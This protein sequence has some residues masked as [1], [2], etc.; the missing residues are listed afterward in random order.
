MHEVE[1]GLG[2]RVGGDVVAAHLE[3]GRGERLQ[4]ARVDVG[5]QHVPGRPDPRGEPRGD[6][7]AAAADLEA[8]AS[9]GRHRDCSR[10]RIVPGSNRAASAARRTAA[11]APA[12]ASR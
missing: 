10:C 12:L 2:Q 4:E 9:P 5:D 11:S 1:G 8:A 6:R 3:V 7:S